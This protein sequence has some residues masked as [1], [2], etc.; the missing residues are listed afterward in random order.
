MEPKPLGDYKSIRNIE[1]ISH[2]GNIVTCENGAMW[3]DLYYITPD[4]GVLSLSEKYNTFYDKVIQKD[5]TFE[6]KSV[7]EFAIY[8]G[9]FIGL[10]SYKAICHMY[11]E[12]YNYKNRIPNEHLPSMT[13]MSYVVK[14]DYGDWSNCFMKPLLYKNFKY[15]TDYEDTWSYVQTSDIILEYGNIK[16]VRINDYMYGVYCEDKMYLIHSID[17]LG[18]GINA[19]LQ[20]KFMIEITN[21]RERRLEI[22]NQNIKANTIDA[23]FDTIMTQAN[24]L[25]V[26]TRHDLLKYY[27]PTFIDEYYSH[28]KLSN[29]T[30]VSFPLTLCRGRMI[31]PKNV[32][33]P[34]DV[35]DKAIDNFITNSTNKYLSATT[36]TNAE[37]ISDILEK[38]GTFEYIMRMED[39][40]ETDSTEGDDNETISDI[41]GTILEIADDRIYVKIT[42]SKII[43]KV[44][45][46]NNLYNLSAKLNYIVSNIETEENSS[47]CKKLDI[48]GFELVN[49][50]AGNPKYY[51]DTECR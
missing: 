48:I 44:L 16:V 18:E 25:K 39:D 10:E 46:P 23:S 32:I 3:N 7:V 28:A 30:I 15:A 42:N 34:L 47:I 17:R 37:S 35:Y 2:V 21:E 49:Q 40:E 41:V 22:T 20:D 38:H 4:G 29:D 51:F 14:E 33:V 50:S 12:V 5:H 9:L 19:L 31:L 8:H 6:P 24:L 27:V 43:N 26:C 36:Y 13:F 1:L 45:Q 11:A